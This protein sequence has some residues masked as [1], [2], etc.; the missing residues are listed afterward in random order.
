MNILSLKSTSCNQFLTGLAERLIHH[1]VIDEGT[2]PYLFKHSHDL[3]EMAPTLLL[4]V[5]LETEEKKA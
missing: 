3:W 1:P 2:M 5:R 4:R